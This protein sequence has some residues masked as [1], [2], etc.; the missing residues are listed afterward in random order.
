VIFSGPMGLHIKIIKTHQ[1][2]RLVFV[3]MVHRCAWLR[4][5]C[6]A[7]HRSGGGAGRCGAAWRHGSS[8]SGQAE[9]IGTKPMKQPLKIKQQTQFVGDL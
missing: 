6:S 9:D 4:L 1:L 2:H 5:V 8:P 7:F 3:S